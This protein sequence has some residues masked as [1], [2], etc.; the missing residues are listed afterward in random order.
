MIILMEVHWF[1]TDYMALEAE[2]VS[3]LGTRVVE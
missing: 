3:I 2:E 1:S